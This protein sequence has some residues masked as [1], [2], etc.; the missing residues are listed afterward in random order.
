VAEITTSNT[1]IKTIDSYVANN[2]RTS[3]YLMQISCNVGYQ[4][5]E[6]LLIHDGSNVLTTE[7]ATLSTNG[8]LGVVSANIASGNVNLLF[9]PINGVNTIRIERKSFTA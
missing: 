5:T 8:N 4:A 7:Y 3:K 9:T 2:Y 6:I 1:S